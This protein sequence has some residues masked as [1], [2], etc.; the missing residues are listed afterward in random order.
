MGFYDV[1]SKATKG[2][3]GIRAAK[4]SVVR[5]IP[6]A[7]TVKN[8]ITRLIYKE[9]VEEPV[10]TPTGDTYYLYN[11]G[12]MSEVL[13]GFTYEGSAITVTQETGY[14]SF[15]CP[16]GVVLSGKISNTHIMN[17][18]EYKRLY[19]E[20]EYIFASTGA[21]PATLKDIYQ[22]MIETVDGSNGQYN[23]MS[24]TFSP[25]R[26]GRDEG[27]WENCN[28]VFNPTWNRVMDSTDDVILKIYSIYVTKE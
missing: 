23:N 19:V 14:L 24:I 7:Y 26:V 5:N 9:E 10:Y 4:G 13:G 15:R 22:M 6:V 21:T 20:Y 18:T 8:G 12:T 2:G 27:F 1:K 25:I 11:R 17:L 16:A 3:I 28:L